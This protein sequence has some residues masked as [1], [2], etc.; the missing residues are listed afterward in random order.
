MSRWDDDH[1]AMKVMVYRAFIVTVIFIQPFHLC[2]RPQVSLVGPNWDYLCPPSLKSVGHSTGLTSVYVMISLIMYIYM[3]LKHKNE[4]S[5]KNPTFSR[6]ILILAK[7][8]F[9]NKVL[10]E[11][12]TIMIDDVRINVAV[13]LCRDN[14]NWLMI[15]QKDFIIKP[16]QEFVF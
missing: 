15:C 14:R 1:L 2:C 11:V 12:F 5:G 10:M 3:G 16:H 9:H 13:N 4:K 7:K 6:S 8:L